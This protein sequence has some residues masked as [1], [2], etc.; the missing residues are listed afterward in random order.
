MVGILIENEKIFKNLEILSKRKELNLCQLKDNKDFGVRFK[1]V[2][3]NGNEY[4]DIILL[5]Q[6]IN[7]DCNIV[8]I[9]SE[10]KGIPTL[11]NITGVNYKE[12]LLPEEPIFIRLNDERILPIEKEL[13]FKDKDLGLIYEGVVLDIQLLMIKIP[14]INQEI[15]FNTLNCILS[16]KLESILISEAKIY[17]DSSGVIDLGLAILDSFNKV[18]DSLIYYA[19]TKNLE[20]EKD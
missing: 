18:S 5:Q 13:R 1:Y 20:K 11:C 15:H 9:I 14:D 19:K 16:E 10:M 3:S 7:E 2:V 12:E 17:R 8:I 4:M 6:L